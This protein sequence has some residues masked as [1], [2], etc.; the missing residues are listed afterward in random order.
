MGEPAHHSL[1]NIVLIKDTPFS[2]WD[3]Q[4]FGV[5]LLKKNGLSVEIWDIT[6]V[7]HPRVPYTG[8]PLPTSMIQAQIFSKKSTLSRSLARLDPIES[9]V[10]LL[11]PFNYRSYYLYHALSKKLIYYIVMVLNAVPVSA[12]RSIRERS[13]ISFWDFFQKFFLYPKKRF[14][15]SALD[16][17]IHRYYR[18]LGVHAADLCLLGGRESGKN[19]PYPVDSSTQLL[20]GHATD[21]DIFLN[22]R[23]TLEKPSSP[24][25]VFID[26]Y[27]PFQNVSYSNDPHVSDPDR[28][29]PSLRRFFTHLEE[30]LALPVV[31]AAHPRVPDIAGYSVF[32]GGRDVQLGDTIGLIHRSELV[33]AHAST[34][35]N[36]AILF[37]KPILFITTDELDN[38]TLKPYI[39]SEA[40]ELGKIPLNVDGPGDIDPTST[41]SIDREKYQCFKENYIKI[42]ESCDEYLWQIVADY[43]KTVER[44]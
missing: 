36:F 26:Q 11:V 32:F 3:Y 15:E 38:S 6:Q 33:I 43:L 34:A 10:L 19:I 30:Q 42:A 29:Y 37:N 20:W 16:L 44:P 7:L 23:D 17:L 5:D 24:F 39:D 41:Y 27:I 28:Y 22:K 21:Y 18:V 4:R 35:T 12:C 25:A 9:A 14:V 31:I 40:F 13:L 2:P 8:H 1:R